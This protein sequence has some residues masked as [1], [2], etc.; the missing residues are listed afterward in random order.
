MHGTTSGPP[1]AATGYVLRPEAADQPFSARTMTRLLLLA[2]VVLPLAIVGVMAAVAWR[3]AWEDARR[4]LRHTAEAAAEYAQR[5]LGTQRLGA[6]MVNE[7]L[8]DLSDA[9]IRAQEA[10]LHARLKRLLDS[11]PMALTIALSDRDA[12]ALLTANVY[13]VPRLSI[14]DREWVQ[15][16]RRAD[17]PT[18]HVSSVT[19][20]RL[21]DN[22]FFGV[23][24]RRAGTGN[25]LAPAEFDG[26]VNISVSP[27]RLGEGLG[28]LTSQPADLMALVREDGEVLARHP[29]FTARLP[30]VS[31]DSPLRAAMAAGAT[32]GHFVARVSMTGVPLR[33]VGEPVLVAYRR[34]AGLPIYATASRPRTALVRKWR[35]EM[36]AAAAVAVPAAG[37]LGLL[38]FLVVR[39][40]RRTA[41]SEAN[42]RAVFEGTSIGMVQADPDSMRLLRVN[43]RFCEMVGRDR[44]ALLG[45]MTFL[46][47]THP[48]DRAANLAG[49][50]EAMARGERYV[51]EKRYVRPDGDEVW[52]R[53]DFALIGDGHGGTRHTVAAVQDTT[54]QREAAAQQALLAREVDH[55]ARNVLAV[56][57]SILSLT[58]A[59]APEDFARVVQDRVAA[60]ARAHTLLAKS[61]WSGADLRLLVAEEIAPFTAESEPGAKPV[62]LEGPAVALAPDAVQPL[63]MV[64]HEL[65]TNAAKYGAFA[66]PGGRLD[67]SWAREAAGLR[68]CWRETLPAPIGAPRRKG[69]GMTVLETVARRQLGGELV[70]DWEARGL[71]CTIRLPARHL[72]K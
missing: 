67:V 33:E 2:A 52:V 43:D 30:P 58:R 53:V 20:G 45:G 31:P 61:H 24:I 12:H 34:L 6:E 38:A 15:A 68:P 5:V 56:V 10:A 1:L 60:L 42:L 28:A 19:T 51:A 9:E 64:L 16:L 50:V 21:D 46:D 41:A 25:G 39:S 37:I 32:E 72:R 69:F 59:E 36:A 27:L 4:D 22:F 55:R 71:C 26:V 70:L 17:A 65:A 63:A 11:V 48:E 13:P 44:A 57:Q 49:F 18:V 47:L 23:S 8:A 3:N 7:M 66:M 35:S 40:Q 29:G 54:A 14:L 62:R